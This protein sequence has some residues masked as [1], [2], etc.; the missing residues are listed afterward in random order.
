MNMV[1]EVND[2]NICTTLLEDKVGNKEYLESLIRLIKNINDNEVICIDGEWGVGKTFF[3]KQFEYLVNNYKK[4]DKVPNFDDIKEDLISIIDNNLIFYYN[5][6][7]NDDHES[8]FNSIIYNI[9]D[10]Y[11]KFK[12][13]VIEQV[14]KEV[15]VKDILK[16]LIKIMSNKLLNIDLNAD[17]I[18]QIKTFEDLSK[19]I[20][21]KE[22]KKKLFK[23]LI[24]KIL[25]N[26][27]MILIVDELDRCNPL[28]ATRM[29]ETIKHF[30]NLENVTVII[31]ANNNELKSI[32][33]K[34]YGIDFNSYGYLN[35]FYD[36]VITIDS[37]RSLDY[38]KKF[39]DFSNHTFLPHD[40]FYAMLNKYRFTLRECNRYRTLYDTAKDYIEAKEIYYMSFNKK[41]IDIIYSIILPI[42]LAFKIKDYSAYNECLNK[43]TSSLKV[44]LKDLKIYLDS[45][46]KGGW[47]YEF[48]DY[49]ENIKE[50]NDEYLFNKIIDV[51]LKIFKT[52]NFEKT[53]MKIIKNSL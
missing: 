7:E 28:Y 24:N 1:L 30:Y 49:S 9:L 27:R 10:E 15:F 23:E 52:H 5:A 35:K 42:I 34:Q 38:C 2:K 3:I 29:L 22:E 12:D 45:T 21:T 48:I 37:A 8:P 36:Y 6:W 17:I 11:P 44:A 31:V 47:L 53:F 51:Y 40:V 32:I 50:M 13:K 18:N 41:E 39:L 46:E 20:N 16:N 43:E 33:N 4:M 14:N 26:K 19:E 25:N